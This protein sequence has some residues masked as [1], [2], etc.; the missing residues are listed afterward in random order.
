LTCA[1]A[2]SDTFSYICNRY[3][4]TPFALDFPAA[5]LAGTNDVSCEVGKD[6]LKLFSGL[7]E[8]QA[9][10]VKG[11]LSVT[12]DEMALKNCKQVPL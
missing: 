9:I 7:R 4:L 5:K 12:D 10:K 6:D 11:T 8:K 2:L 3:G 1:G